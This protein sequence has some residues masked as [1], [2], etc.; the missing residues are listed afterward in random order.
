M[1]AEEQVCPNCGDGPL[2]EKQGVPA[3][4]FLGPNLLPG[5]GVLGVLAGS[6]DLIACQNC[7]FVQFFIAKSFRN[8]LAKS[9]SVFLEKGFNRRRNLPD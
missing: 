2:Y 3:T 7:G 1:N 4:G 6:F 5:L 9:G 8:G